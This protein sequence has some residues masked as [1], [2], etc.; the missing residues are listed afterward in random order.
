MR[1]L[2][3]EAGAGVDRTLDGHEQ[4]VSRFYATAAK[5]NQAPYPP[6]A[7]ASMPRGGT[8]AASYVGER[9]TS[10]YLVKNGPL[11]TDTTYTRVLGGT[12][13]HWE[14]KTPRML[15]SDFRMRSRFD[16]GRDWPISYEELAPFYARP[17]ARLGVSGRRRGPGR[18]GSAAS[19]RLPFPMRG[20]PCPIWTRRSPQVVDG[21]PVDLDGE[22]FELKVR[23]LRAGAQRNPQSL[24][25]DGKGFTP[26]GAVSTSQVEDRSAAARA[27]ST[28]CRSALC[29]PSTAPTGHSPRRYRPAGRPV[30]AG[31]RA[32]KVHI[33][34]TDGPG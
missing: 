18:A 21:M 14:A 17:S 13:M 15:P 9:D 34:P 16:Q 5:D 3:L 22:K 28:A 7:N 11:A 32:S 27:T 23:H 26:V 6:N 33:D 2:L 25:D 31:G 24:Y 12:T 30:G 1:V 4:Y 10:S 19:A 8:Y 29:R 20:Y